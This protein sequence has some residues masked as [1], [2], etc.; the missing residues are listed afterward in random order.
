M[1]SQ[2]SITIREVTPDDA[3]I[4]VRFLVEL[5][6]ENLPVLFRRLR[7]RTVEQQHD[8]IQRHLSTPRST[9]MIALAN[10]MVVG[11]LDFHGNARAQCEHVGGFG[12]SVAQS[13]R[14]HK[15][16]TKLIEELFEW[17][18]LQKVR[19]VEL[20]VFSNNAGAFKLYEHLGFVLEGR[21]REAVLVE[22]TY[23]DTF[24]MAKLI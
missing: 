15:V 16:A 13:W 4:M 1:S 12:V 3:E 21:R 10:G 19:R 9:I 14:R 11:I 7:P 22:G 24:Q 2:D 8:H 18:R 6:A 20:E 17:A 5:D 23:I